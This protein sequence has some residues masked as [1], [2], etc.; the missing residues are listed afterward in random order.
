MTEQV[1]AELLKLA[2]GE[3]QRWQASWTA[4]SGTDMAEGELYKLTRDF[5]RGVAE[6]G[7][8]E[9]AITQMDGRWRAYATENNRGVESAS[10]IKYGP[11]KGLSSREH[12]WVSPDKFQERARHLRTMVRLV[13]ERQVGND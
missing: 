12:R 6:D 3:D 1:K 7:E 9:S 8:V 5:Y 4:L 2:H 13:M 10:K 11:R